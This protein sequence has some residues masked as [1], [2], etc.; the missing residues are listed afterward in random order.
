MSPLFKTVAVLGASY[1]GSSAARVLA[2]G[3]PKGW[4]VVLIDRNTHMNHLYAFP[5][6][7]VLPGHEHK[8]FIPYSGFFSSETQ[9][10]SPHAILHAHVTSISPHALTLSR[11]FPEHGIKEP[12][13]TL[14]FQYL[15]YALGSH[16][17]AP[18]DLWNP[19]NTPAGTK[20]E[21]IQWFKRCQTRFAHANS[22]LVVGGGALGIQYASDIA[23]AY[24][25]KRV[26]LLHS[27]T[28]LLPRF[29]DAMHTE[30]VSGLTA[31]NVDVILGDRLDLSS[32]SAGKTVR[33]GAGGEE[34]VVRTES[35]REIHAELVLLCTGQKPNTELLTT[36]SPDVIVPEGPPR[37][38]LG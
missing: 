37:E 3:L 28:K 22:I 36:L 5:R 21:G 17:P 15:V 14:D 25:G 27:R 23:E 7:S 8:A 32:V 38:W 1:G 19:A 10:P 24:P 12:G 18:I 16:L 13:R 31:L 35:G 6:Y 4:R 30:I 29:D 33:I 2:Q 9:E 26:T 34:R 20:A 11:A